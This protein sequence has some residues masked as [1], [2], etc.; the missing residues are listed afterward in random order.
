MKI[1]SFYLFVI[2]GF[3]CYSQNPNFHYK[4]HVSELNYCSFLGGNK[5]GP[6]IFSNLQ[7][8]YFYDGVTIKQI[9]QSEDLGK[10]DFIQSEIFQIDGHFWFTSYTG[11]WR[12]D[13]ENNKSEKFQIIDNIADTINTEY[14]LFYYDSLEKYLLLLGGSS[15][16]SFDITTKSFIDE[17]IGQTRGKRFLVIVQNEDT[18]EIYASPWIYGPGL[19]YFVKKT[20]SDSFTRGILNLGGYSDLQFSKGLNIDSTVYFCSNNGLLA[21]SMDNSSSIKMYYN[22]IDD[23]LVDMVLHDKQLIISTKNNQLALFDLELLKYIGAGKSLSINENLTSSNIG[24]LH[25]LNDVLWVTQ[26]DKGLVSIDLRTPY[27]SLTSESSNPLFLDV[28]N[29]IWSVQKNG[30][31]QLITTQG[32]ELFNAS[33]LSIANPLKFIRDSDN[34]I[35]LLTRSSIFS[36]VQRQKKY[37]INRI[38][39]LE[40]A[41]LFDVAKNLEGDIS[42]LQSDSICTFQYFNQRLYKVSCKSNFQSE[43]LNHWNINDSLI[44]RSLDQ[45]KIEIHSFQDTITFNISGTV[46]DVYYSE[47]DGDIY[48]STSQGLFKY[49]Y[50]GFVESV[51]MPHIIENIEVLGLRKFSWGKVIIHPNVVFILGPDGNLS[52]SLKL[53]NKIF[54]PHQIQIDSINK[55]IHIS[56]NGSYLVFKNQDIVQLPELNINNIDVQNYTAEIRLTDNIVPKLEFKNNQNDIS[57]N[58]SVIDFFNQEESRIAYTL[59]DNPNNYNYVSSGGEIEYVS[60][61]PGSYFLKVIPLGIGGLKGKETT[62]AWS[63]APPFY[64]TTWFRTLSVAGL[65]S[66]GW[67]FNFTYTRQKLKKKERELQRQKELSAQREKIADDLHDELGTE[68]SKILYLSDEA[69]ETTDSDKKEGLVRD[70]TQLAASSISNMRDMLWVLEQKNDTLDSLLTRIRTNTQKTLRD[71]G[72]ALHFDYRQS[73]A[74]RHKSRSEAYRHKSAQPAVSKYQATES[75]DLKTVVVEGELRRQVLLVVKEAIHNVIKHA[76]ASQVNISARL[77]NGKLEITI[78]DNGKGIGETNQHSSGSRGLDSMKRR[79]NKIGADLQIG[80]VK[81]KGTKVELLIPLP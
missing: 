46:N 34:E 40:S 22:E 54:S 69:S 57:I 12:F 52:K 6:I 79:S 28:S 74:C 10:N 50:E 38:Y 53:Q 56:N 72:I 43:I 41:V 13:A 5:N 2:L 81:P 62:I 17:V 44:I 42:V 4:A 60:L 20:R 7:S 27:L 19:E 30:T 1:I 80:A 71:Y 25:L 36:I 35:W 33:N 15:V 63:I 8:I 49:Y 77:E 37:A 14:H 24:E 39:N 18:R 29:N 9:F 23:H 11:L 47:I 16:W 3:S 65:V 61:S 45:N 55:I 64:A 26:L 48:F 21:L 75:Q 66:L 31:A 70:I 32:E 67:L 68:L 51:P 73:E 78:V 58:V 59:Y 76:A